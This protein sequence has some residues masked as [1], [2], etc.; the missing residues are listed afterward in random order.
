MS[1]RARPQRTE[2]KSPIM[3]RDGRPS[4]ALL[5]NSFAPYRIPFYN[6]LARR[7]RL[8]VSVD[9]LRENHREW[10]IDEREFEFDWVCTRSLAIPRPGAHQEGRILVPLNVAALLRHFRPD[11]VVSS[12]L[13][14][15]T[16]TATAYCR[17]RHRPLTIWWE[18]TL[19][20]EATERG[21]TRVRRRALL[22]R[23][24]RIW[25]NGQ[26]SSRYLA[27]CGVPESR[28][29]LGMTGMDTA[30]WSREVAEARVAARPK[31]REQF[32]LR[33]TVLL[34]VGRLSTRKGISQLLDALSLVSEDLDLPPWSLL[35]VGSGVLEQDVTAWAHSHPAVPVGLTGFVQ[36]PRLPGYYA[37]GDLFV[38]PSLKDCWALVCLEALAAGLPQVTS[39][40]TGSADDLVTSSEVGDVVDPRDVRSF[41]HHLAE[42]IRRGP[43]TVPEAVRV[44]ALD[45]W[46]T[47]AMVGR[48]MESIHASL[49][50]GARRDQ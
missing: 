31:I 43:Q 7:T 8:L 18:G 38:M 29:D 24:A 49:G 17:A 27:S 19:Q 44:H 2:G 14:A 33:G 9:V 30:R 41:A 5:A 4:V 45:A 36:P 22:K 39:S 40:M 20:T 28:I 12:E 3:E 1:S 13:G 25:G 50:D 15:R 16:V 32:G 23:A 21:F 47:T 35:F 46:S 6:A 11:V 34:Y 48:A 42:R 26:D 37:A 10:S